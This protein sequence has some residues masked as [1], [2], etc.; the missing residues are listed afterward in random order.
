MG[1]GGGVVHV[2]G[3]HHLVLYSEVVKS[4][5]VVRGLTLKGVQ[6]F[7]REVVKFIPF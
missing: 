3:G 1:T 6:V 5:D 7:H 2:V 4:Q